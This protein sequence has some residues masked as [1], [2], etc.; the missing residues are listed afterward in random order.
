MDDKT[1]SND[2]T[3]DESKGREIIKD[4]ATKNKNK[5]SLTPLPNQKWKMLPEDGNTW[6][7]YFTEILSTKEKEKNEMNDNDTSEKEKEKEKSDDDLE[8]DEEL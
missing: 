2:D 6:K 8:L 7:K 4:D 5:T 3:N 1:T